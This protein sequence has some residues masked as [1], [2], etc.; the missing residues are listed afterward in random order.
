M[1]LNPLNQIEPYLIIAVVVLF[2]L[3][4]Q[5]LKRVYFLPYIDVMEAR[6]ARLVAAEAQADEAVA[7]LE[8]AERQAGELVD[9]ARERADRIVREAR[10]RAESERRLAAVTAGEQAGKALEEGRARIA[11]AR[12]T[13]LE[14]LRS[15]A[16]DCVGIACEKLIGEADPATVEAAVDKLLARKVS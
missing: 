16:L 14:R 11:A 13:E 3:T 12:T 1:D 4:Y 2:A 15:E 6:E 10:D 9:S 7:I 8:D 5:V